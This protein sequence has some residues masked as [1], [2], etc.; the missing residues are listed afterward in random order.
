MQKREAKSQNNNNN[1]SNQMTFNQVQRTSTQTPQDKGSV[2]PSTGSSGTGTSKRSNKKKSY[3][4]T[5]MFQLEVFDQ[6]DWKTY[7]GI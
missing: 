7:L 5:P 4:R 2:T 1:S 3:N 6:F